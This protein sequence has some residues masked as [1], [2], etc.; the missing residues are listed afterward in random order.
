ME[1]REEAVRAVS[2]PENK[3]DTRRHN[4][5]ARMMIK[6]TVVMG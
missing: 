3:S 5:T 2:L 1:A 4:A 6:S